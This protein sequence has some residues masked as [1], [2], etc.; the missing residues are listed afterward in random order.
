MLVHRHVD[1]VGVHQALALQT[2]TVFVHYRPLQVLVHVATFDHHCHWDMPMY[3]SRS[4]VEPV[5]NLYKNGALPSR[6]NYRKGKN[7]DV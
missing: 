2:V 4:K 5:F 3:L 6:N 7:V 1:V